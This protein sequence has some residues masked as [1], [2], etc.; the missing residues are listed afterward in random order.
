MHLFI[1]DIQTQH[2]PGS[3]DRV[4]LDACR[5][6]LSRRYHRV[7][8]NIHPLRRNEK[9]I[10]KNLFQYIWMLSVD[11]QN[12]KDHLQNNIQHLKISKYYMK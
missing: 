10:I 6:S 11:K 3:A 7:H 5:V 9:K 12:M 2:P 4:S 8:H 1:R